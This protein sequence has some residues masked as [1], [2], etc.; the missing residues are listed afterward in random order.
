MI[1]FRESEERSAL[2]PPATEGQWADLFLPHTAEQPG[3]QFR[4]QPGGSRH[5]AEKVDSEGG[6]AQV[7][8]TVRALALDVFGHVGSFGGRECSQQEQFVTIV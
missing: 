4:I 5:L 1:S 6:F 8:Q 3:L 2:V 7:F